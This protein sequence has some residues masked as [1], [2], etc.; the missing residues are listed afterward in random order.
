MKASKLSAEQRD[1]I[2]VI[3]GLAIIAVV[4]IHSTPDFSPGVEIFFK[5][6]VNF[7]VGTFLFLSGML[8]D[9]GC[10]NPAKRIKKVLVPYVV[11]SLIYAIINSRFKMGIIPFLVLYGK[12]LLLGTGATMFYYIFVYCEL[13][14]LIPLIDRLAHSKYR[15]LGFTISPLEIVSFRVIPMLLGISL[16]PYLRTIIRVLCLGWFSYF[17]LGYLLGNGLITIRCSRKQICAFLTAAVV[18]QMIEGYLYY[19]AGS[20]SAGTQVKLSAVLTGCVFCALIYEYIF[21][22]TK[23]R[24]DKVCQLMKCIGDNSF[25]IFFCHIAVMKLETSIIPA[26]NN[27]V[28][29]PLKALLTVFVSLAFATIIHNSLGKYSKFLGC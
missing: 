17:Y 16:H 11:W 12:Y 21:Y 7:A 29:F 13:T 4:F 6:F 15:M 24:Y 28:F 22:G 23:L 20:K 10:W 18:L 26:L 19:L 5:P 2:Q 1:R 25:G 3:R 14:L 8:S 9:A 27:D